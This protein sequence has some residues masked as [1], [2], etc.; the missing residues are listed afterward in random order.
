MITGVISGDP[1]ARRASSPSLFLSLS[2]A[3]KKSPRRLCIAIRIDLPHGATGYGNVFGRLPCDTSRPLMYR[4]A[5]QSMREPSCKE[6]RR[7]AGRVGSMRECRSLSCP[8]TTPVLLSSWP[9]ACSASPSFSLSLSF[10]LTL[11]QEAS[12]KSIQG[13]SRDR[14]RYRA[15]SWHV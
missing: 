4:G 14:T 3:L 7:N 9:F 12:T 5:A 15:S 1:V 8:K 2:L 13:L 6:S 11:E 10:F